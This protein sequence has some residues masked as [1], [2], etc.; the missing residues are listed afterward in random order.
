MARRHQPKPRG[1]N[2]HLNYTFDE[3]AAAVGVS[4]ATIRR[5]VKAGELSA[6]MDLKPFLILG[7]DLADHRRKARVPKR[8]LGRTEFL[9]FKCRAPRP[10]ALDVADYI[11]TSTRTGNLKA[12]C[13][14]CATIMNR[15]ISAKALPSFRAVLTIVVRERSNT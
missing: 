1:V 11:P 4:K 2:R 7:A 13:P 3:A 6:I 5:R 8:R 9:C 10:A 12:L 14:E 15:A